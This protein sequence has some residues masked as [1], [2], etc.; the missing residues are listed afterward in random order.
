MQCS[1]HKIGLE[2]VVQVGRTDHPRWLMFQSGQGMQAR[3]RKGASEASCW[4]WVQGGGGGGVKPE[5]SRARVP[6]SKGLDS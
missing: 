1:V 4:W 2:S 5:S 3:E 6:G